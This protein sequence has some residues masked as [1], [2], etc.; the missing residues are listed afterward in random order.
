VDFFYKQRQYISA[1]RLAAPIYWCF[2]TGSEMFAAHCPFSR[3]LPID[4]DR[5][6]RNGKY[7][8]YQ[9]GGRFKNK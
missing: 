9:D 6:S 2:I 3:I 8:F 1:R 4:L 5:A 7:V